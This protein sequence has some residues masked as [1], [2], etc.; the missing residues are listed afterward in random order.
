MSYRTG[1]I[2]QVIMLYELQWR[3]SEIHSAV[4]VP[5]MHKSV[6]K[7]DDMLTLCSCIKHQEFPPG[8]MH[9]KKKRACKYDI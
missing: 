5:N 2:H 9:A 3:S 6:R 4:P 7:S 8:H 1:L